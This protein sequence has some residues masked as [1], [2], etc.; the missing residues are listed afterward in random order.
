M[1][2]ALLLLAAAGGPNPTMINAPMFFAIVPKT[3]RDFRLQVSIG[4]HDFEHKSLDGKMAAAAYEAAI[5]SACADQ[6][7]A[8]TSALVAV[9]VGNGVKRASALSNAAADL[10][11]YVQTSIERYRDQMSPPK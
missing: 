6:A 7:K 2:F 10:D 8:L 9:D 1:L 4:I 11:D 5:K 3:F